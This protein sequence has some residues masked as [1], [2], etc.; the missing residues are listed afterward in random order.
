MTPCHY[1]KKPV[2]VEAVLVE[3]TMTFGP[4]EWVIRG[5]EGEFYPCKASIFDATYEATT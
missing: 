1:R 5:V 2:T 3:G 4:G